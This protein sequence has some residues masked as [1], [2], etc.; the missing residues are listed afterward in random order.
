MVERRPHLILTHCIYSSVVVL[1][2]MQFLFYLPIALYFVIKM[3][4]HSNIGL[5]FIRIF[6]SAIIILGQLGVKQGQTGGL[7]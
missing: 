5:L 4:L 6:E 7:G 1:V 3:C 2:H